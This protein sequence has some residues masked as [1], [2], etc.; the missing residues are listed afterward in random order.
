MHQAIRWHED[1]VTADF[2][3]FGLANIRKM[4]KTPLT[5]GVFAGHARTV[6]GYANALE[7]LDL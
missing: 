2:G 1:A 6:D 7:G 4:C 5:D 3:T